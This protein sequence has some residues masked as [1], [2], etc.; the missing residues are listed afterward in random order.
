MLNIIGAIVAGLI[1]GALAR[2]FYPGEV[3]MGWLTTIA[4]GVGGSLLAGLAFHRGRGGF[5]RPG[6][7]SSILGAMALILI[8]RLLGL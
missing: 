4:L 8:G 5:D 1:I 7:L 2:F 6:C 3:E